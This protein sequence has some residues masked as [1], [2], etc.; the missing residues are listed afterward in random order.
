M[1][2]H[3]PDPLYARCQLRLDAAV[4]LKHCKRERGFDPV[5]GGKACL[6]NDAS[7]IAAA[8]HLAHHGYG[9]TFMSSMSHMVCFELRT[10]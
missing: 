2:K 6:R 8:E 5:H 7:L 3:T 1:S 10:A 4:I 9:R